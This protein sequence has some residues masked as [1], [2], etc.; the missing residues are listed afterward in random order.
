MSCAAC[1]HSNPV[2]AKCRL[3]CGTPFAMRCASCGVELLPAAKGSLELA[4]PLDPEAWHRI[5]ERFFEILTEGVHRLEGTVNQADSRIEAPGS[6]R[7]RRPSMPAPGRARWR[8]RP[9]VRPEPDSRARS[10]R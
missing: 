9:D 3:G 1:G 5:L 6:A 7:S 8:A 4:E 2:R 10:P